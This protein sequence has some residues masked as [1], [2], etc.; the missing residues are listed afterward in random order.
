MPK[1]NTIPK[2]DPSEADFDA[3]R[4]ALLKATR[5]TCAKVAAR[6][7]TWHLAVLAQDTALSSGKRAYI[8]GALKERDPD[9][10]A[11]Q[12]ATL[13]KMGQPDFAAIDTITQRAE[14][15]ILQTARA[16]LHRKGNTAGRCR[17]LD[18]VIAARPAPSAPRSKPSA[19]PAQTLEVVN[20]SA[21]AKTPK[22]FESSTVELSKDF[23]S[24][25]GDALKQAIREA[26]HNTEQHLQAAVAWCVYTGALLT[27]AKH[28]IQPP[29]WKHWLKENFSDIS[30]STANRYRKLYQ[31]LS[32]N[33]RLT[34]EELLALPHAA[35]EEQE[36]IL[37]KIEKA[38][39]T[40]SIR[41][42]YLDFDIEPDPRGGRR[43]GAG[44]PMRNPLEEAAHERDFWHDIIKKLETRANRRTWAHCYKAD[45]EA[46][47]S[48]FIQLSQD[49]GQSL[50]ES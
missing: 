42:L 33:K 1:T 49:I 16:L 2:L 47:Y 35:A 24:L 34:Q 27:H 23:T 18:A 10:A 17:D 14:L 26:Y 22:T 32:T 30:Y 43:D 46:L 15:P 21:P 8:L 7:A 29:N 13:V 44:R 28:T 31:A 9:P 41:Q 45:R 25:A 50:R 48:L 3:I 6:A 20:E 37:R 4:D 5:K 40:R 39:G 36:K 11:G 12:L 19:S 38:V